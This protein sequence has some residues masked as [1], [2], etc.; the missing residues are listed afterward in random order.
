MHQA[1]G[2]TNSVEESIILDTSEAT[3]NCDDPLQIR[4]LRKLEASLQRL[5]QV[6]TSRCAKSILY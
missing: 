5:M 1:V 3:Q 6:K 4:R 2:T